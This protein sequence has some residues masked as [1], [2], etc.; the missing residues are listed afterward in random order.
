MARPPRAGSFSYIGFHRYLVTV[1]THQRRRWFADDQYAGEL[2]AHIS[3]FFGQ[4]RFDVSVYCVMPDHVHMLLEGASET[5]DLRDAVSRWKQWTGYSWRVRHG[6]RLWQPGY[7]DRVLREA[8]DTQ[9]VVG[10]V[11]QNPVRAGL[12]RTPGEYPHVGSSRYAM[13]DLETHAG[14]WSPPWSGG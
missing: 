6:V 13:T 9:A 10:Y 11:L 4:R 12:A 1:G 3:P 7:H 14:A 5:A 8:D 2:A